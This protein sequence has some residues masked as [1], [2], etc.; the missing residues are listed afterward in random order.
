V[1]SQHIL[2]D[3]EESLTPSSFPPAV[4][5]LHELQALFFF[6]L[7]FKQKKFCCNLCRLF[8]SKPLMNP[9]HN[10]LFVGR[11]LSTGAF[12]QVVN[13]Y[14]PA[15][16]GNAYQFCFYFVPLRQKNKNARLI[17]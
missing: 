17:T 5:S 2:D 3:V 4:N 6:V 15:F 14:T 7:I 10:A 12:E 11:Q 16:N 9:T 1:K 8:F 13:E